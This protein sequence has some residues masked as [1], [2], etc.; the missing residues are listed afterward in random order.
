[1][2]LPGIET[3]RLCL[4]PFREEHVE[5]IHEVWT[6]PSIRRFLWDNETISLG[7]A[8]ASV[9]QSVALAEEFGIGMWTIHERESGELIGFVGFRMVAGLA[10]PEILYG[11]RPE[12]CGRGFATEAVRAALT[13]AFRAGLYDRIFAGGDPANEASFR[14]MERVGMRRLKYPFAPA[15]ESVYYSVRRDRFDPDP[16]LTYLPGE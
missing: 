4:R 16:D 3:S 10:R 13:H 2:S 8:L 9:R 6:E 11:L 1:M 12:H 7:S 15:P 5:A 14:L